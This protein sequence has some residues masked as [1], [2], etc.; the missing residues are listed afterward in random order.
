IHNLMDTLKRIRMIAESLNPY[1]W[2]FVRVRHPSPLPIAA[3]PGLPLVV[4]R[5]CI[6]GVFHNGIWSNHTD[7]I[8]FYHKL[9]VAGKNIGSGG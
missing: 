9:S 8:S 2:W 6:Q 1:R 3:E 7:L 4:P 5:P